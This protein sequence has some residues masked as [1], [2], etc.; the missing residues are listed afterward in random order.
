[1]RAFHEQLPPPL[2]RFPQLDML[3]TRAV[4][5]EAYPTHTRTFEQYCIRQAKGRRTQT[6]SPWTEGYYRCWCQTHPCS[7]R[8]ESQVECC[9][10]IALSQQTADKIPTADVHRAR[11]HN[12]GCPVV[13]DE[14]GC[15]HSFR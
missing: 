15:V 14:E 8:C 7:S 5:F 10:G 9:W 11:Q 1:M 13:C 6:E 2:P 3:V 4:V 12:K